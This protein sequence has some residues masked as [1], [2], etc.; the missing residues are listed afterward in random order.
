VVLDHV[1]GSAHTVVIP[2]PAARADVLGHGDLDMVHIVRVPQ[3]R[4]NREVKRVIPAG[5]ADLIEFLGNFTQPLKRVI[6][7]E[8]TLDKPDA[9]RE[10][11]PHRLI[12]RRPRIRLHRGLHLGREI[13][14]RPR[15]PAETHQRKTR[16]QQPP[17]REVI[18]GRHELLPGKVTGHPEE[19]QRRR[20]GDPVQTAVTRITEGI[21]PT[22]RSPFK[23]GLHLGF[24]C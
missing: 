12:K 23:R 6:V 10:L 3:R 8:L 5:T 15:T 17:V 20:T 14:M 22:A 21:T 2:G 1:P 7:V 11:V 16:R 13:L 9:L 24:Q 19:H 4:R 18:H